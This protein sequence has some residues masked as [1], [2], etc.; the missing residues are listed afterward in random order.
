[1]VAHTCYERDARV[2]RTAEA[3]AK[4]GHR[5][6]VVC[7]M[8]ADKFGKGRL[9][10]VEIYRMPVRRVRGTKL[11]YLLGYVAFL[12]LATAAVA[13][14]HMLHRYH[15]VYVHNMPDLLVLSAI[16]PAILQTPVVLDVHDPM[17]ELFSSIFPGRMSRVLQRVLLLQER[18]S[19]RLATCVITVHEGMRELLLRR[20]VSS[21]RLH[22]V[23]NLPDPAVFSECAMQAVP[24]AGFT[25]VY[26][27]TV[28]PRHRLDLLIEAAA[29]LRA[30]MPDLHLK[31]VGE[32]PDL[33]RLRLMAS[34]CGVQDMVTFEGAVPMEQVPQVLKAAD[35]AI[36]SYADDAFGNLVFPTKALEAMM[37]G[38]PV[39]CPRISAVLR[40][41][42]DTMLFYY[43]P[44]DVQS[45]VGQIRLLRS[46]PELVAARVANAR[47]LLS[48]FSW[49]DE[50]QRL[51]EIVENL[52]K[53][54]GKKRCAE[55][56][57]RKADGA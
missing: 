35:G 24:R 25:L 57:V 2:R 17:P 15:L 18:I 43:D 55:N 48:R 9:N 41:L 44:R 5:V 8:D 19:H 7:L 53:R 28:S 52:C 50:K 6:D 38:V 33:P 22:V 13:F 56:G 36:A 11:Q 14:L 31:I 4:A 45:L 40:Y 27:G 32:G 49:D 30:D 39:L 37:V 21:D 46:S 42:D 34:S 29:I 16:V 26:A 20:G 51:F 12:I 54:R 10:N 47:Q 3:F 1:M 23:H